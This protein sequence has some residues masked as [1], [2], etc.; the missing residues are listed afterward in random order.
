MAFAK[1]HPLA[2]F[3][4]VIF[5]IVEIVTDSFW[6]LTLARGSSDAAGREGYSAKLEH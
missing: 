3:P 4:I 6:A 5:Y 2:I 1:M